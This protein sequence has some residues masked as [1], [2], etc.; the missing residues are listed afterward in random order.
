MTGTHVAEVKK[1]HTSYKL[2]LLPLVV[3]AFALLAYD[4]DLYLE[5]VIHIVTVPAVL[6]PLVYRKSPWRKTPTGKALMNMAAAIAIIF[7][8]RLTGLWWLF[9]GHEYAYALGVSYVGIAITYQF[10]VMLRLKYL[11]ALENNPE[12]QP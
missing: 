1:R 9:P 10:F 11:A 2:L 7:T 12:V 5:T 8:I 4:P 3:A 6:Y